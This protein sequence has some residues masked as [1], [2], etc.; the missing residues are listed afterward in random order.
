MYHL[1]K[2]FNYYYISANFIIDNHCYCDHR[3][4]V[5]CYVYAR[6][7]HCMSCIPQPGLKPVALVLGGSADRLIL[8]RIIFSMTFPRTERSDMG[9]YAFF[10]LGIGT[11]VA[12]FQHDRSLPSC[13]ERVYKCV[14]WCKKVLGAFFN[15]E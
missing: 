1:S 11:L 3:I 7:V 9:L 2:S 13:K 10:F 15:M 12:V 6:H 14:S 5:Q 8:C 4:M